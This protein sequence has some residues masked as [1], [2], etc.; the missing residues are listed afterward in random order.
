[1][2]YI[3]AAIVAVLIINSATADPATDALRAQAA[4]DAYNNCMAEW[5]YRVHPAHWTED[6]VIR[7]CYRRASEVLQ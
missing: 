2:R 3:L 5:P 4:K 7:N 1:M 6:E